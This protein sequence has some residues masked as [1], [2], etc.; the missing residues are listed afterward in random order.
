VNRCLAQTLGHLAAPAMIQGRHWIVE[1]QARRM[2]GGCQLGEEDGQGDAGL[3]A[4]AQ[5]GMDLRPVVGEQFH[6]M[7]RRSIF[8][9]GTDDIDPHPASRVATP[10]TSRLPEQTWFFGSALQ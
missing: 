7:L 5:H 9:A 10:S 6:L 3:L 1:H 8:P 2:A 4:L